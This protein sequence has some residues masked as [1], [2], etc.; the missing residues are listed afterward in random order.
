MIDF[1]RIYFDDKTSIDKYFMD[2]RRKSTIREIKK[3][4]GENTK[5][6]RLHNMSLVS[7]EKGTY[8]EGSLHSYHNAMKGRKSKNEKDKWFNYNDFTYQNLLEV[9]EDLEKR[10]KYDLSKTRMTICE[11]GFNVNLDME[12]NR[13]ID[14]FI[15]M[16]KLKLPCRD[17][18]NQ[19]SMKFK[20]FDLDNYYVKIYD[21]SLQYG[22]KDNIL[23]F[24][25]GF[26]TDELKELNIRSLKDLLDTDK[27]EFLFHSLLKKYD[28]FLI[29]DR[30]DGN[31]TMPQKARRKMVLYTHPQYWIELLDE[32]KY[33]RRKSS[34]QELE[35]LI[36]KYGLDKRRKYLRHL[37]EEKFKQLLYS[38]ERYYSY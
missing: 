25:V 1:I 5:I 34:K 28:D 10:L 14:K 4:E 36:H 19:K 23:R 22:L 15:L 12:P 33:E 29:V 26:K 20:R 2:G 24:E 37:I 3:E 11:M 16:F 38:D 13:F 35:Y 18:K 7:T 6:A 30:F 32:K 9:L 27:L 31:K 8:L 17:P 21:K